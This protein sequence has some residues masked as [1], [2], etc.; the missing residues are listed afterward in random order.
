MVNNKS[1]DLKKYKDITGSIKLQQEVHSIDGSNIIESDSDVLL[2]FSFDIVNSSLYKTINYYGWSIVLNFILSE[3][4]KDVKAKINR[5]ELWRVF[6]DEIVFIVKIYD[7]ESVYEYIEYIYDILMHYCNMIDEGVCFDRIDNFSDTVIDLMK[8]QDVVSLQACAWMAV[9]TDKK[10]IYASK[11]RCC[12]ENVFEIIDEGTDKKFYEFMGIDIDTGFRLS[13]QTREKRL[14]VSFELAYILSQKRDFVRRLNIIS[15]RKLKGVWGNS[16]YPIIW[17]Y[18]AEKHNNINFKSSIPFDA[19]EQDE[20]YAEFF[21]KK[22]FAKYMYDD[23]R[24][25]LKKICSDKKLDNKIK[26]IEQLIEKSS[27]SSNCNKPY[28]N[29]FKLELHCVA[30]C[31]SNDKILLVKR[32]KKDILSKKWEFGCAKANSTQMLTKTVE[33]EYYSD[34]KIKIKLVVDENRTDVEPVPLAV[35]QVEKGDE[36]QKGI[37]FLAKILEGDIRL[38]KEKHSDF[39][40]IGENEIDTLKDDECIPDI[41][42]TLKKAFDMIHRIEEKNND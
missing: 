12:V 21:E 5:A 28:L 38:N 25:A 2:F 17:Y 20:I 33:S 15:Y 32:C 31:Y 23:I 11:K 37:I 4:R 10:N 30:V 26:R 18:D 6:G 3:L 9:V 8:L 27:K 29:N 16:P 24:N 34:F 42:D 41:K 14:T 7:I 35:Y 19:I 39:R 1:I 40:M 22:K 13:K 36:T